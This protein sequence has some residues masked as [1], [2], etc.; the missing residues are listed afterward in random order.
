M[1][2][3]GL[4]FLILFINLFA[5]ASFAQTN[6][7]DKDF[8]VSISIKDQTFL[9]ASADWLVHVKIT[10][11]S[12]RVLNTRDCGLIFRFKKTAPETKSANAL[13]D[14]ALQERLIK[15]NETF[16]FEAN[17]KNLRWVAP[18]KSSIFILER[19]DQTEYKPALSGNYSL[20]ATVNKNEEAGS[21]KGAVRRMRVV[22]I[23]SNTLAVKVAPKADK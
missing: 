4:L 23:T 3:P 7:P 6:V 15:Q 17:L 11:L 18:A 9:Q 16:E 2:K 20:T 19:K 21:D 14:Y 5:A 22:S 13:G 8:N 12:G 10:N 1:M